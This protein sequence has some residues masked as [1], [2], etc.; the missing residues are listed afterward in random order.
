MLGPELTCPLL[1]VA[2][3]QRLASM[4]SMQAEAQRIIARMADKLLEVGLTEQTVRCARLLVCHA[5]RCSLLCHTWA[6]GYGVRLTVPAMW[7]SCPF[8]Q[9]TDGCR[10]WPVW[11]TTR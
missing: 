1:Q 11:E 9:F 10:W 6:G 8:C 5:I 3:L 4:G 7:L 2:L